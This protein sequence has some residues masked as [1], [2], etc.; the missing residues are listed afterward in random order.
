LQALWLNTQTVVAVLAMVFLAPLAAIGGWR[1]RTHGLYRLAGC[2]AAILF[3]VMT[4]IFTFPG[5]RGGLFHSAGALLP[6][7]YAAALVGLDVVIKWMASR[8][9][10]WN[11]GTARQVFGCGL[12]GLAVLVTAVVYYRV[13]V[14]AA[15]WRQPDPTYTQLAVW[16]E[17]QG[18]AGELV[19]VGDPPSYWYTTG[20]P[21][22]VLPNEPLET[23]LEVARRYGAIYI[24]LDSNAPLPLRSLYRGERRD[25]RLEL[26]QDLPDDAHLYRVQY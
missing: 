7:I 14:V 23:T 15:R 20:R 2:Y 3:A 26:V 19:M 6:F 1:L 17:S 5:P 4:F 24:V 12:V 11:P 9:A 13:V 25:P 8:R 21:S 10:T 18:Q 16:L 22:I